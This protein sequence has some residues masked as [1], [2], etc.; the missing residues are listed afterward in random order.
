MTEWQMYVAAGLVGAIWFCA[1][2]LFLM[3]RD[4]PP[5]PT[6]REYNTEAVVTSDVTGY[7]DTATVVT[8]DVTSDDV[9][10]GG[11]DAEGEGI[12]ESLPIV[13]PR[14]LNAKERAYA[15]ELYAR[16]V[17]KNKLCEKFFGNKNS[18]RMA[19]LTEALEG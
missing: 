2:T 1:V 8:G 6:A 3:W 18:S 10:G 13:P 9:Q 12:E 5:F 4:Q 19:F 15:R 14:K 11:G 16:G 7:D 17:S